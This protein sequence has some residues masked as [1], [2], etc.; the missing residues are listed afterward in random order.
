[1][2]D[3]IRSPPPQNYAQ[4]AL[5]QHLMSLTAA[6]AAEKGGPYWDVGERRKTKVIQQLVYKQRVTLYCAEKRTKYG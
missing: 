3:Y 2:N 6:E 4:L 1:M 5:N